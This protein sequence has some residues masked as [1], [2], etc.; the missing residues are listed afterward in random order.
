M[1]EEGG[2]QAQDY[3]LVTES[4]QVYR[5]KQNNKYSETVNRSFGYTGKGVATYPNGDTYD[6]HF[7]NGVSYHA[8]LCFQ[9]IIN[10][11]VFLM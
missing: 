7:V 9:T 8:K 2:E 4:G 6:G 5:S 3:K 1:A 10:R 11:L